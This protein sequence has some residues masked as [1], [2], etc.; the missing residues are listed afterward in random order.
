MS[1]S[2][3]PISSATNPNPHQ[4]N[5]VTSTLR[6]EA[7]KTH[8]LIDAAAQQFEQDAK[9][10]EEKETRI[11]GKLEKLKNSSKDMASRLKIASFLAI[12]AFAVAI[13]YSYRENLKSCALF[14]IHKA[15]HPLTV[16]RGRLSLH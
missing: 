9:L 2:T 12:S 6:E 3:S 16:L 14:C 1:T 10:L 11:I 13:I 4:D 8:A 5:S 15:L 7:R